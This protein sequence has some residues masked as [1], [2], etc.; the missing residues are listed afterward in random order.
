MINPDGS[1]NTA[2][3]K[4]LVPLILVENQKTHTLSSGILADLAP[5]VLTLMGLAIPSEMGGTV[6]AE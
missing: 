6:L 4:N 1:P 5:T 2:H 3:S